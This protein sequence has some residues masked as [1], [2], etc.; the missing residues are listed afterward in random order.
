MLVVSEKSN[1]FRKVGAEQARGGAVGNIMV[2]AR[3]KDSG[4]CSG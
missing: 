3:L 4:L 2:E 1:E